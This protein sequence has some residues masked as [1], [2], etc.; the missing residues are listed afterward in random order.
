VQLKLQGIGLERKSPCAR[1]VGGDAVAALVG[2]VGT[3]A[4]I[5]M[6]AK[7]DD[8]DWRATA[9]AR[10]VRTAIPG[11]RPLWI[12]P[13]QVKLPVH[14]EDVRLSI[15]LETAVD[16]AGGAPARDRGVRCGGREGWWR[17]IPS[18]GE[19]LAMCDI[20]REHV[21]P[22]GVPVGG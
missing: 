3:D 1:K 17:S 5:G 15:D 7:L 13:G 21:Q 11:G 18:T 19:I 14:G 20:V 6:E 10:E 9:G 8:R 2:K 4:N 16:G 22:Q 12:E